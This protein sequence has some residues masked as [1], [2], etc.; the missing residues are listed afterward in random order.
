MLCKLDLDSLYRVLLTDDTVKSLYISR[1]RG[2]S[3][4][5]TKLPQV[6]DVIEKP[7]LNLQLALALRAIVKFLARI[8]SPAFHVW[9]F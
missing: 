5:F 8:C 1:H 3:L 9:Y 7:S 6:R 2:F 4:L